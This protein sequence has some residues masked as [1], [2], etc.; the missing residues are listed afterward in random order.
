MKSKV[1][2]LFIAL[3]CIACPSYAQVSFFNDAPTPTFIADNDVVASTPISVI[4]EPRFDVGHVWNNNGKR[5]IVKDRFYDGTEWQYRVAEVITADNLVST[6]RF[7][8]KQ[9]PY[10]NRQWTYPGN[11]TSHLQGHNHQV[12]NNVLASLSPSEQVTLHNQLHS[13]RQERFSQ[14]YG[15]QCPG[16]V[17][18]TSPAQ[19][20]YS[21]QATFQ[22]SA[23]VIYRSSQPIYR[24]RSNCPGGVCPTR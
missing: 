15:D 2:L 14:F 11:I 22:P 3:C 8:L 1:S 10:D 4:P 16:G 13:S 23:R 17:C 24:S 19:V 9:T 20:T 5:Y 18:P 7:Q 6:S 21:A 12:P